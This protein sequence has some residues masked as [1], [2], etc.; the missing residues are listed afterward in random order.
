[1]LVSGSRQV[2][3]ENIA[4]SDSGSL[5]EK[6]RNN[7]TGGILIEEGTVN[8]AVRKCVLTGIR[9]NGIWTHSLYGS[10]RNRDGRIVEN[11]FRQIGR[12]AIQVGHTLRITVENN[13]GSEIGYPAR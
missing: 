8:F 1:M 6:G 12:D 4:V 2:A 10:Q 13:K 9:G 11:T 5:N 7:T 3:I